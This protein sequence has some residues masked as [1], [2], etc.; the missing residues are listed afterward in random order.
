M[1]RRVAGESEGEKEQG[2]AA[3]IPKFRYCKI[4]ENEFPKEILRKLKNP[5]SALFYIENSSAEEI[6]KAIDEIIEII[7]DEQ[8]KKAVH[9][10][11]TWLRNLAER[12]RLRDDKGE[13]YRIYNPGEVKNMLT[14]TLEKIREEGIREGIERGIE[15]GRREELAELIRIYLVTR[16]DEAPAD[17]LEGLKKVQDIQ[18]LENLAPRI[19]K[20]QNLEEVERLL[21]SF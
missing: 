13:D 1:Q 10:F 16:F 4:A 21:E 7:M 14:A 15:K 8:D 9:R 20:C 19:Y 3:Y 11:I 12:K 5:V 6:G 17:F 2:L 18:E